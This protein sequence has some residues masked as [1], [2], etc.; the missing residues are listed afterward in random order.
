MLTN[1]RAVFAVEAGR[2]HS[3]SSFCKRLS[4]GHA[5]R[6]LPRSE[7]VCSNEC[8]LGNELRD[9]LRASCSSEH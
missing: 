8:L 2:R 1:R 7:L 3:R 9:Y 6:R 5:L 4:K